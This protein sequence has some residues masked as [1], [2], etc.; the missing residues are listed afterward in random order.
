MFIE[1]HWHLGLVL[2]PFRVGEHV[3]SPHWSTVGIIK[4][5]WRWVLHLLLINTTIQPFNIS[6]PARQNFQKPDPTYQPLNSMSIDWCRT[7]KMNAIAAKISWIRTHPILSSFLLML[8][9]SWAVTTSSLIFTLI[10]QCFIVL[11]FIVFKDNIRTKSEP[12]VFLCYISWKVVYL[13]NWYPLDR[14]T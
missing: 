4:Q 11:K 3:Y 13:S 7:P 14:S 2:L 1:L 8:R 9:L 6:S 5:T 10:I 12:V